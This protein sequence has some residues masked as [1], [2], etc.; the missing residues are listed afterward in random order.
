MYVVTKKNIRTK[1]KQ[2]K[3]TG[4]NGVAMIPTFF[5]I[6]T[7]HS[8]Q[9]EKN[10]KEKRRNNKHQNIKHTHT[11]KKCL[12]KKYNTCLRIIVR[13]ILHISVVIVHKLV[14]IVKI[15]GLRFLQFV[16]LQNLSINSVLLLNILK[17]KKQNQ[18][19]PKQKQFNDTKTNAILS[20]KT[21][22]KKTFFSKIAQNRIAADCTGCR[23]L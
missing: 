18:I 6:S 22:K 13:I 21:N 7:K 23:V 1:H 3:N 17:N 19:N 2:K 10:A 5:F 11:Q 16:D 14:V 4:K 20:Q 15:L 8:K 9:T 12:C